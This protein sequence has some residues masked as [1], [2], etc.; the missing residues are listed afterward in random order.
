MNTAIFPN[1]GDKQN[2]IVLSVHRAHWEV[3]PDISNTKNVFLMQVSSKER[4]KVC[5]VAEQEGMRFYKLNNLLPDDHFFTIS[6]E[7]M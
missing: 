3:V 2:S 5:V 7:E 6:L 1:A 4:K